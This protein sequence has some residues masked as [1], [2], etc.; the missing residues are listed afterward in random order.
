VLSVPL[1]FGLKVLILLAVGLIILGPVLDETDD[2]GSVVLYFSRSS[3]EFFLTLLKLPI[4]L[5]VGV[6]TML[7]FSC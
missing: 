4:L 6:L 5:M 1:T 7:D 2:N 3:S